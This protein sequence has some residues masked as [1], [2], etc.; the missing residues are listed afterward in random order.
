MRGPFQR[1]AFHFDMHLL[2]S[3]KKHSV[4]LITFFNLSS[5]S[6]FSRDKKLK[7]ERTL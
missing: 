2:T 1:R 6:A 3:S 7:C 5:L 4:K